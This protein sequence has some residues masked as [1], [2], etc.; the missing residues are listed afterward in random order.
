MGTP[1]HLSR[2]PLEPEM[3]AFWSLIL[4]PMVPNITFSGYRFLCCHTVTSEIGFRPKVRSKLSPA[5]RQSGFRP[6]CPLCGL[7]LKI[8][9]TL[10]SR[11]GKITIFDRFSAHNLPQ[12]YFC[13]AIYASI[14]LAHA[15]TPTQ[16]LTF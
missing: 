14:A 1:W 7:A 11:P 16:T 10:F 15:I 2:Q 3:G 6:C 13:S 9:I 8:R 12:L 5:P 4:L